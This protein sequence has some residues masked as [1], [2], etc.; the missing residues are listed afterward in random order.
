MYQIRCDL[1][2]FSYFARLP[3]ISAVVLSYANFVK[4]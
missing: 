4:L 1:C 3:A 2:S